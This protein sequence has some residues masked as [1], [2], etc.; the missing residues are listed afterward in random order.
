MDMSYR[1]GGTSRVEQ[2]EDTVRRQGGHRALYWT[3]Y[4][5]RIG[6]YNCCD[7]MRFIGAFGRYGS[8]AEYVA[9]PE[10]C[11]H[12]MPDEM[13]FDIG[14]LCE[15]F[16]IGAQAISRATVHLPG[17][18]RRKNCYS[19]SFR[20]SPRPSRLPRQSQMKQTRLF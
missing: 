16:T 10:R 20:I 15:P 9:V 2:E 12:L 18:L 14:A 5:C 4:P 11:I 6:K 8:F 1:N 3:C 7:Q 13:S 19:W 17:Q